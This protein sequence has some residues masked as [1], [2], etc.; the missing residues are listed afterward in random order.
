MGTPRRLF[1]CLGSF[2]L[3]SLI[4]VNN[5]HPS[6]RDPKIMKNTKQVHTLRDAYSSV[7][8]PLQNDFGTQSLPP[9]NPTI[10]SFQAKPSNKTTVLFLPLVEQAFVLFYSR[11]WNE[12]EMR[13]ELRILVPFTTQWLHLGP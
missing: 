2:I 4:I 1:K 3:L 9:T 6:K 8:S 5:D 11:V 12:R 10:Q 7:F 13:S